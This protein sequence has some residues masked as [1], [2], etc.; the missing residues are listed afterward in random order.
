MVR[1]GD[2]APDFRL[3][4][5]L[6]PGDVSLAEQ[7]RGGAVVLGLFRGL[8]CPFCRRQIAQLSALHEPLARL[9]A[10]VLVV[11]NTPRDRAALY[12]RPRPPLVT[13]LADATASTHR[14]F[15]VPCVVPDEMFA[16]VRVNPTGELPAPLHP[17]EANRVLNDKDHFV[18]TAVDEEVFARHGTQLAAHYVIDRDGIVRWASLEA[19]QGV[20]TVASFPG[21]TDILAA[22][23]A[24]IVAARTA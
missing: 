19:E 23:R 9:G 8:H 10:S 16:A 4:A 22:V 17:M 7:L 3:P 13:L 1:P 21:P 24:S 14:L 18:T 5:V 12:F 20:H 11:V 2:A 15:G 6:A